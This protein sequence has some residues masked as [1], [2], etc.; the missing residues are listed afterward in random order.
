MNVA[1]LILGELT[2]HTLSTK[3]FLHHLIEWILLLLWFDAYSLFSAVKWD[4][5]QLTKPEEVRF[6]IFN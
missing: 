5:L 6:S 4:M 2:L 1:V 3:T